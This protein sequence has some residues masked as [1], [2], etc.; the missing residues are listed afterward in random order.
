MRTSAKSILA[1]LAASIVIVVIV[2]GTALALRSLQASPAGSI[3]L[4]ERATTFSTEIGNVICEMTLTGTLGERIP[5]GV[6]SGAG[7]I[8]EVATTNCRSN[9]EE[10]RPVIRITFL[11]APYAI[12]FNAFL[13]TLP[14]ITGVLIIIQNV[15]MLVSVRA[16]VIGFECLYRGDVPALGTLVGGVLQRVRPLPNITI[17]NPRRLS[18]TCPA[19]IGVQSNF[20]ITPEPSIRLL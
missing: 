18:G 3:R 8:L 19:T 10:F 11:F 15:Q 6:G 16:P 5:K 4:T 7:S 1:A 2:S 14:N 20:L 13:G 9:L 12:V 17:G